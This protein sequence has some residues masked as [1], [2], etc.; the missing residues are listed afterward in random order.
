MAHEGSAED[1]VLYEVLGSHNSNHGIALRYA[2]LR[3]SREM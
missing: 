2:S 3:F 1:L